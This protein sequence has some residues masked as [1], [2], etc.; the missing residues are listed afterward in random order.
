MNFHQIKPSAQELM[1]TARQQTRLSDIIDSDIEEPLDR[2]LQ[3]LNTEAQLSAEGAKGMEQQILRLLRNRL[4]MQRDFQ[5]HPEIN[6]QQ[7]APPLIVI[8]GPR[9]GSTKLHKM[10]AASDDFIYLLCWQGM[11]LSL[12]TGNLDEDPA[13]RIE[14]A[15]KRV[16]WFNERAPQSRQIHELSTF[17]P[18][19]ENMIYEHR[20]YGPYMMPFVNVPGYCQWYMEH[21]DY[22][23]ELAF[24]KQAMKYLQW[25]F[26]DGDIRPWLLKNPGYLGYEPLLREIFPD[27]ALVTTHRDPVSVTSSGKSLNCHFHK[28]YSDV[29]RTENMGRD[30]LEGISTSWNNHLDI[31][32][33]H[34]DLKILDIAYTELTRNAERVAENVY[35]HADMPLSDKARDAMRKWD[36][37][38]KQHKHGVHKHNLDRPCETPDIV[39]EKFSRYIDRFGD[40]F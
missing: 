33:S 34:P 24:L 26:H 29:D 32:D 14:E 35:A 23:G 18:E 10:L 16:R 7:I 4:R 13:E 3:S 2:C 36:D 27:A 8:G 15:D 25:Q 30:V 40:R 20:L 17:E 11:S 5:M 31:R 22:R 1:A 39:R 9:S 6:D 37:E 21:Q 28:A 38:N 12:I 19:E